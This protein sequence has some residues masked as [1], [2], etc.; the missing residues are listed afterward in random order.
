MVRYS[1]AEVGYVARI[2]FSL[3]GTTR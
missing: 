3:R 2:L 1:L